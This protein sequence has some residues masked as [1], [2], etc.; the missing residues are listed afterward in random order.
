MLNNRRTSTLSGHTYLITQRFLE[1]IGHAECTGI[2]QRVINEAE[3]GMLQAV[4]EHTKGNQTRAANL[5]GITR[6]TLR[7]R[8]DRHKLR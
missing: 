7:Q 2:Y 8:L 4:M 5:L 1:D 6:A 3:I